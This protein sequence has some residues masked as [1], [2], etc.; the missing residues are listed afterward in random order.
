MTY[1][2]M[3]VEMSALG[4]NPTGPPAIHS[5]VFHRGVTDFAAMTD[6]PQGAA[7]KASEEFYVRRDNR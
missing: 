2:E 7:L 3:L 6:V 4:E 5:W 1:Q